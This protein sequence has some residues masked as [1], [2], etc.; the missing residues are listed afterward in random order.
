MLRRR[1][2]KTNLRATGENVRAVR[3]NNDLNIII[4]LFTHGE[5]VLL[6]RFLRSLSLRRMKSLWE[7]ARK[8]RTR[9]SDELLDL[10]SM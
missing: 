10:I 6:K 3:L 9:V 8:D 7:S 5:I 1:V 2:L 4:N